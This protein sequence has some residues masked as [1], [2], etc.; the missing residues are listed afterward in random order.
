MGKE[1]LKKSIANATGV[2]KKFVDIYLSSGSVKVNA[3]VKA[4]EAGVSPTAIKSSVAEKVTPEVIVKEVKKVPNIE[5][6]A[7][8]GSL[9]DISATSPT[10][11]AKKVKVASKAAKAEGLVNKTGN[12]TA[13][14]DT[15]S[16]LIPSLATTLGIVLVL[17]NNLA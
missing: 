12:I 1:T 6:A 5:K 14:A 16:D 3:K 13:A 4:T 17:G 10:T 11:T 15:A 2:D 9:D 7:K 8:E